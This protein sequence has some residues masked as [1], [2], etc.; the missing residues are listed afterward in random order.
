MVRWLRSQIRAIT[1]Q[2]NTLHSFPRNVVEIAGFFLKY[3]DGVL[4]NIYRS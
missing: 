3:Y 4:V 1:N 2:A